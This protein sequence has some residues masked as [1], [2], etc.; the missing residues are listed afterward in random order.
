MYVTT[1]YIRF[2]CIVACRKTQYHRYSKA[3][4]EERGERERIGARDGVFIEDK[5]I[6]AELYNSTTIFTRLRLSPNTARKFQFGILATSRVVSLNSPHFTL[7]LWCSPIEFQFIL[8]FYV[9]KGCRRWRERERE[10]SCTMHSE[11][12]R[13][14]RKTLKIIT[15]FM[16]RKSLL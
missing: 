10:R 3:S 7:R 9:L 15:V 1:I 16:L 6:G 8:F 2:T 14:M 5:H 13:Q 11:R 4:E 12:F